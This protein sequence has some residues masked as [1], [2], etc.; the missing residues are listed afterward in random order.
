MFGVQ[1]QAEVGWGNPELFLRGV[2]LALVLGLLH[3]QYVK[4][5]GSFLATV[6]Y[7]WLLTV[8]Y[9]SY[10]A[11]TFYWVTFI[12]FRL[13][14]FVGVF[15]ILRRLVS[16]FQTSRPLLPTPGAER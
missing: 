5:S 7:I 14:V 10:R 13:L 1:S 16:I 4:R 3:R 15:L 6:S 12:A 2:V 8:I 11:A 9:Y